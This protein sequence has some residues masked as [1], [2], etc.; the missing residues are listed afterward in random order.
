M[1]NILPLEYKTALQQSQLYRQV[2]R[3]ALVMIIISCGLVMTQLITEWLLQRWQRSLP[4]NHQLTAINQAERQ[5]LEQLVTK[6]QQTS[7]AVQATAA[8]WRNPLIDLAQ[9]LRDTPTAIQLQTVSIDYDTNIVSMN[10][11]AADRTSLVNYQQFLSDQPFL[12]EVSFP[13][14]DL[15]VKEHIPFSVEAILS[16]D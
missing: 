2:W 4:T 6:L 14:N 13:L 8:N 15:A 3:L 11:T 12:A 7:V 1:L 10:G 9:V 5:E 16:Y